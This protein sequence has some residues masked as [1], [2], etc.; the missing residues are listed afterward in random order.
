M[1]L[2]FYD[3]KRAPSPRRIRIMLALKNIA[4]DVI[5]IDLM[6]AEQLSDEYK[7]IN[8]EGTVP[9]LMLTNG[10]VLTNVAAIATWLEAT[11][12]EPA[13]LGTTPEEKAEIA[14]WQSLIEQD[15]AYAVP[16]ALRN[17]EPA[18]KGRA[19]PGLVDYEQIPQ[20]RARGL[21]MMDVFM[22]RLEKHLEGKAY[23]V[24]Q[25]VSVVDITAVCFLDFMRVVGKKITDDFPNMKQ[26][27]DNLAK[28]EAF[29]L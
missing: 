13:L 23:I 21:Q 26:W 15:L 27:R 12:P 16:H 4:H 7:K 2:K 14:G 5:Q 24:A 28:N 10:T 20:L 3:T 25:R 6:Q 9:A 8:P 1:S 29:T 11:Y 19:L 18:F 22:A 17:T